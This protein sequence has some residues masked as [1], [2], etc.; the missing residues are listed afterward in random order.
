MTGPYRR[1]PVPYASINNTNLYYEKGGTGAPVIFVH[2]VREHIALLDQVGPERA[3]EQR[4]A[5]VEATY[6]SLWQPRE[7]KARGRLPAFLAHEEWVK[8]QVQHI[9][10]ARRVQYYAAELRGMQ[11]YMQ[12]DLYSDAR[13]ITC[14]TLVLHGSDDRMDPLSYGVE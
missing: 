6:Y 3:F 4:P 14:P 10:T 1:K 13:Q 2:G 8:E 7:E 12:R 11:A 5:G 9:P